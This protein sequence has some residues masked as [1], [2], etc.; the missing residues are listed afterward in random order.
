MAKITK[1]LEING[2][3]FSIETGSIA[4]QAGGSVI[5]RYGD[6]MV[7]VA[8]TGDNRPKPFDFLPLTCEYR[9]RMYAA[10]KIPGGFFK[11][12]GRP[13][14]KGILAARLMDRPM[15]PLFPKTWRSEI[16]IIAH[17]ISHDVENDTSVL[18]LT[19]GSAAASISDLPFDGPIAGIR[20][21][22]VDGAFITNPT[23]TQLEKSDMNIIVA[24]SSEAITM[25]EGGF[26]EVSETDVVAALDY[27][28]KACQ[29]LIEIQK[30]LVAEV[31]KAK[32]DVPVSEDVA[33]LHG[34]VADAYSSKI[35]EAFEVHGKHERAGALKAIKEEIRS[36]FALGE[37]AAPGE[38]EAQRKRLGNI[39][40]KL[41]KHLM[42]TRLLAEGVRLD[43]RS[44]DEIRPISV[45]VGVLPRA[46]GSAVFTRGET[47][48]LVAATLG[49]RHDEQRIE[50]LDEEGWSRFMLHYNFPPFSVG[51]CRRIAGPGRRE[52]GH[53]ALAKRAVEPLMPDEYPYVVRL[54]SDIMES[55][56]SSSMA[57]VCGSSLALMDAG[58]PIKAPVAGIAMGLVKEGEQFAVLSDITG[59][60]DHLGDMDFKVTGTSKGIT[61]FQMDTKI[62]G[63]SGEIMTRALNQAR[64]GRLHILDEMAKGIDAPR[65]EMSRFAPRIVTVQINSERIRDI[66]GPG[67]KTIRAI[68]EQSGAK[69]DVNDGGLVTIASPDDDAC[70]RALKMIKEIT[71]EAEVGKLYLGIV[72]KIVDFGAFVEIF[73][74]TDGLVHI[75]QL[76]KN[77]VDSVADVVQE[78]DEVLVKCIE[79]DKSGKIRLSRKDALG[80]KLTTEAQA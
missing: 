38:A 45:E 48:A 73:P 71:Q 9:P 44:P 74:G 75:S 54:V 5:V 52:I 34:Q 69:I 36:R 37:D 41:V 76:A 24:A 32:R 16:Q 11:R 61:A 57:S 12:E 63:V 62:A 14:P 3:T 29:P 26:A 65:D 10:G 28:F 13:G 49:T 23:K 72:K 2:Q 67:G 4:K 39:H 31:G 77:R 59:D 68:T 22:R 1:S 56:G 66:I 17:V 55:N 18:A 60:E 78:G 42:R 35:L 46:H 6:S 8:A 53:G 19:G 30:E 79:V 33:D 51:E 64:E 70:Q 80:M 40:G 15:R 43:G 21:G 20:V 7:F 58:V 25:V 27:A 50:E 47:Q